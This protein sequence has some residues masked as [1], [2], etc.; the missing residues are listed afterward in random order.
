MAYDKKLLFRIQSVA[1]T[2]KHLFRM[3][4][5]GGVGYLFKGNMCFGIFQDF[6]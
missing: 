2:K 5:F 3:N 1:D 6:L 4:M